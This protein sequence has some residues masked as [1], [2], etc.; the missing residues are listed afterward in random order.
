LE[1]GVPKESVFKVADMKT[2]AETAANKLRQDK[3]LTDTQRAQALKAIR[4]ET[5]KTLAELVGP[6]RAKAYSA[7]GGWWLRNIAPKD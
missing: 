5:E 2:E 1:A 3:S 4:T 7:N 6:R